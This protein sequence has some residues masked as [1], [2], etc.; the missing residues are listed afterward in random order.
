MNISPLIVDNNWKTLTEKQKFELWLFASTKLFYGTDK[1]AWEQNVAELTC[2]TKDW[3][4]QPYQVRDR[5]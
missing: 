2:L 4:L 5:L 3:G 1:E